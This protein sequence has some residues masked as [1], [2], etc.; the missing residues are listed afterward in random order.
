MRAAVV[1][2][3]RLDVTR[4]PGGAWADVGDVAVHATGLPSAQWNGGHVT[5]PQPRLDLVERFFAERSLPWGVLV[6]AELD[7]AAPG[8][9]LLREQP[10]MSRALPGPPPRWPAG[11]SVRGDAPA[12]D[13]ASVQA[14]AFGDDPD[15]ALAFVEP[16]AAAPWSRFL[17]AYDGAAPVGTAQVVLAGGSAGVYGVAVVPGARRSGLGAALTAG[18]LELASAA[19]FRRAHLNPSA[20][21]RGVYARLG[22]TDLP[23]W[24]IWAPGA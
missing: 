8:L 19:G 22:F 11:L 15:L 9:H 5:G 3:W 20:P 17:T 23:A 7:L 10:L 14:A 4:R 16:Q 13:V 21:G 2:G 18:V 24:R 6:P 1:A 12:A